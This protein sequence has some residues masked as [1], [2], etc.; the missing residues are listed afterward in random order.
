MKHSS[1]FKASLVM[2]VT[3]ISLLMPQKISAQSTVY[4]FMRKI[5]NTE[6][7]VFQ[8]SKP[9]FDMVG[10]VTKTQQVK[11]AMVL[12]LN[13]QAA[14][15]RKAVFA[16]TGKTIF[17]I[18]ATYTNPVNAKTAKYA[19]EIQLNLT[20]GATY[21]VF[22]TRK[23]FNDFKMELLSDKEAEK[24]LKDKKFVALDDYDEVN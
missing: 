2:L 9:I 6:L 12:P 5:C 17:S 22:I 19:A 15:K 8:N 20:D 16:A 14:C 1:F 11:S 7:D 23:G 4:F 3:V 18:D 13:T 21:Y 24:M 10:P